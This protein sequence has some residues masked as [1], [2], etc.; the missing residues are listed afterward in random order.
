MFLNKALLELN[1]KKD[2]QAMETLYRLYNLL[3]VY[4]ANEKDT[5]RVKTTDD[6]I[7]VVSRFRS[8]FLGI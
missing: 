3:R 8:I 5:K 7:D 1:Q 4:R 2:M 6:L